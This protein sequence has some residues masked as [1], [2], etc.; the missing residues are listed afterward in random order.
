MANYASREMESR[1]SWT[2]NAPP[3]FTPIPRPHAPYQQSGAPGSMFGFPLVLCVDTRRSPAPHGSDV[4]DLDFDKIIDCRN[5]A[6]GR[7]FAVCVS[8]SFLS[9]R[10]PR[11]PVCQPH[12]RRPR[13]GAPRAI[14]PHGRI[15]QSLRPPPSQTQPQRRAIFAAA[16]EFIHSN[17]DEMMTIERIAHAA[18]CGV[19]AFTI[20]LPA[21]FPQHDADVGAA[22]TRLER[23][24]NEIV[25]SDGSLSV[26]G[27][28]TRH[29]FGNAGR[30]SDVIGKPTRSPSGKLYQGPS[31][32]PA[33]GLKTSNLNSN[34]NQPKPA[35]FGWQTHN[36]SLA[37]RP[38]YMA[39][40][41]CLRE[42]T[43]FAFLDR[44]EAGKASVL[45]GDAA[46]NNCDTAH[47]PGQNLR[48]GAP[49]SNR[50]RRSPGWMG[51]CRATK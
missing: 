17:A 33:L 50:D 19:R 21:S 4:G 41:K 35:G 40:A 49:T 47:L 6:R 25:R 36:R 14:N 5:G 38:A 37:W 28:A 30:F 31:A 43:D 13:R 3:S 42:S 23:A 32:Q 48:R 1:P 29:G 2:R 44:G 15:P 20:G 16:E 26:L 22:P 10:G 12:H 34:W 11:S 7:H 51:V 27:V 45:R 24:R 18:G 9:L 8:S 46:S 39:S